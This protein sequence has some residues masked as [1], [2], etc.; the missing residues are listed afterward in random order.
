MKLSDV[1]DGQSEFVDANTFVY[2][3]VP[4]PTLGPRCIAFLQRIARGD[5]AGFTSSQL[6]SDVAHRLMSLEACAAFG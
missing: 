4:E 3:F 6:L 1:P 5:I 2:A